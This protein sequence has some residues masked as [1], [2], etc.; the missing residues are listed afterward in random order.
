M[1][2]I[3]ITM[4]G[5]GSRFLK[6]G[7]NKPKYMIE[8]KGKTL[9]EWSVISLNQF[10]INENKFIFIV[11]KSD[12]ATNFIKERCEKME[13]NHY[14]I[15]EI[16]GLTDGQATTALF[17][18]EYWNAEKPV[19]IYNIDTHIQ[20]DAIQPSDYNGDGW[21]PCFEAPGAS[22][23]FAKLDANNKVV[24]VREKVRISDYATIGLYGFSSAN[25]YLKVYEEYYSKPENLEKGERYIAPLYNQ[26]IQDGLDVRIMK[27]N[28]EKVHVIGTPEELEQFKNND[29]VMNHI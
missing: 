29:Y 18:K 12:C 15:I 27:I 19:L 11:K 14:H 20:P 4:G 25:L 26:L 7:Y 5:V 16:D 28:K 3:V 24:E 23:S 22:W 1:F 10:I 2:N 6:A 8:V 13:L 17:A 9:F 21:I